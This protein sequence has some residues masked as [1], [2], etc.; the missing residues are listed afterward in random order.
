VCNNNQL[1]LLLLDQSGDVVNAVLDDD[2]LWALVNFLTGSLRGNAI[3]NKKGR[4]DICVRLCA[5]AA[6][7]QR[8]CCSV[9]LCCSYVDP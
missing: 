5:A 4:K 9:N 1:G 2:W 6:V 3:T 7:L 8:L